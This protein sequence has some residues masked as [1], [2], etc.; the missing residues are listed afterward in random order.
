MGLTGL[1]GYLLASKIEDLP[2]AW[3]V[4]TVVF[5]NFNKVCTSQVRTLIQFAFAVL[6]LTCWTR[7]TV[8]HVVYVVPS[9]GAAAL[10][11]DQAVCV[12]YAGYLGSRSGS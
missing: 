9:T 3:F 1:A 11:N 7:G 6:F 5:V 4:Q 2:F 8:F 12:R 10:E